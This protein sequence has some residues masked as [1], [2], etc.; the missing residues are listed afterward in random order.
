MNRPPAMTQISDTLFNEIAERLH[1][2]GPV[3][4]E[5][6]AH[7]MKLF[8]PIYLQKGDFLVKA[9]ERLP[10]F[11]FLL[12]GLM[13]HYFLRTDGTE[14]TVDFARTYDLVGEYNNLLLDKPA[15]HFVQALEPCVIIAAPIAELRAS[16][17]RFP[18]LERIS[19]QFSEQYLY[20]IMAQLSQY[21]IR[22]AE[23]RYVHLL[24]NE[25]DLIQRVPQVILAS[26]VGVTPVTLSRIRNRLA[27]QD[28]GYTS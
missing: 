4:Q 23:E 15:D 21:T 14:I 13:R 9:G 20:R 19:R 2:T 11:G 25:P 6:I 1:I 28:V 26:Y 12:N 17:D 16:Y 10:L 8:S 3:D 24:T 7:L 22:N 27:R 18:A 5:V